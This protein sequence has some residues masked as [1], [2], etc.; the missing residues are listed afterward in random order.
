MR[1]IIITGASGALGISLVAQALEAGFRVRGCARTA[2]GTQRLREMF[3]DAQASAAFHHW[4]VRTPMPDAVFANLAPSTVAVHLATAA[5]TPKSMHLWTTEEVKGQM[6]VAVVGLWQVV[7]GTLAPMI[8]A[9]GGHISLVSTPAARATPIP[10]G[11]SAYAAGKVA[12]ERLLDALEAEYG[13]RGIT[14]STF[15]APLMQ[16]PL[17]L[18]W[19]AAALAGIRAVETCED[20][21]DVAHRLLQHLEGSLAPNDGDLALSDQV[22]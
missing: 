14:T 20:P 18:A 17:T 2:A 7:Q 9:G 16:T 5:F 19:P 1:D 10:K 11:F 8:R 22:S 6:D 21:H 12:A 15:V 4:D 3:S 13:T